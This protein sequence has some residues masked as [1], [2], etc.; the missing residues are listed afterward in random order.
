M[1]SLVAC[2]DGE[3][4]L[5]EQ[6]GIQTREEINAQNQNLQEWADKL[7]I[8]LDKK[9]FNSPVISLI[10]AF[11]C[12]SFI[13]LSSSFFLWSMTSLHVSGW[14]KI[15]FSSNALQSMS[16]LSDCAVAAPFSEASLLAR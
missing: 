8:D 3:E 12:S 15:S 1:F 11:L 7:E 13:L 16:G 9:V 2:S 10:S 4:G 5:K 6:T 14:F